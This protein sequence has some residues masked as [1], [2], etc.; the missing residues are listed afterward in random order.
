METGR[1]RNELHYL[2][3][4][5]ASLQQVAARLAD[6]QY[7]LVT[8]VAN[9]EKDLFGPDRFRLY[10]IFSHPSA[11]LFVSVVYLLRTGND[12]YP[13]I[14]PHFGGVEPFE[15]EISDLLGLR[16]QGQALNRGHGARL[17]QGCYPAGLYPLRRDKSLVEIRQ[18]VRDFFCRNHACQASNSHRVHGR[19]LREIGDGEMLLPVGPIHA[20]VI[21]PGH[22]LFHLGGEVVDKLEIK[23]GYT[24]KGIERL[25]QEFPLCDGRGTKLA[26]F[27]S[28]DSAFSHA[29]AYC[30]AVEKLMDVSIPLPARLARALFLELEHLANHIGDVGALAHDVA[31]DLIASDLAVL[32]E[33]V[34]EL[35]RQT[36]GHRLLFDI[37]RPGGVALEASL[38]TQKIGKEI[39]NVAREFEA[40]SQTLGQMQAFRRRAVGISVLQPAM[41]IKL[42][43]TGLVARASGLQRDFRL[44]HP[45]PEGIYTTSAF[46][47]IITQEGKRAR[48]FGETTGDVFARFVERARQVEISVQL[49]TFM[50]GQWNDTWRERD[51][52]ADIVFP[53]A[54]RR[55]TAL[56][57]AEGWRGDIVYWLMVDSA[58]RIYRCKVRDPSMLNWPALEEAMIGAYLSDFPLT[59]K[60]FNLS[61][62]VN[63]L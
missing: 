50:L 11:D 13:S 36:S 27:V 5:D 40:L 39:T 6:D 62:S 33:N 9:D 52:V 19:H 55:R 46:R 28:G 22:F 63:D 14:R 54:I 1:Y 41:A 21:E 45:D 12:T 37:N 17:H 61:Y 38:D 24:H 53:D 18:A 26:E 58:G 3:P 29:L 44:N 49:I 31:V 23:L 8:L 34:L 30:R 7:F 47:E 10:Y 48:A 59:N 20:G 51:Y 25:F 16:P 60:S 42:G 35:C 56:G 15:R 43:V 57:Y 32:R 2:A 4:N